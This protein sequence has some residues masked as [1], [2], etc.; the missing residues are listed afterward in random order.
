[1]KDPEKIIQ[2][3]ASFFGD[4]ENNF[5]TLLEIAEEYRKAEMSPIFLYDQRQNALYCVAEETFN[6]KLH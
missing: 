2:E 5:K 4:E 1:M 6:K 3:S